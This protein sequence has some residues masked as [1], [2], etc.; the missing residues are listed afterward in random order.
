MQKA[1]TYVNLVLLGIISLVFVKN[2]L[3]K[4]CL[5][6]LKQNILEFNVKRIIIAFKYIR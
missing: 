2:Y 3:T 6:F 1:V 4:P 5:V